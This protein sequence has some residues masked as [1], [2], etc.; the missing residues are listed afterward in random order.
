MGLRSTKRMTH[1]EVQD[2]SRL[3]YL[4]GNKVIDATAILNS[5]PGGNEC[6]LKYKG[7]DITTH[8]NYHS[9]AAKRTILSCKIAKLHPKLTKIG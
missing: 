4:V 7:Q 9:G 2:S 5:H 8:L 3:L 6:L 1:Q